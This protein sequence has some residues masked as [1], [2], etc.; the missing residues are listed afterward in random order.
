MKRQNIL[1][2]IIFALL[3]IP[4]LFNIFNSGEEGYF[5]GLWDALTL[6]IVNIGGVLIFLSIFHNT[7][8]CSKDFSVYKLIWLQELFIILGIFG[9]VLGITSLIVNMEIPP[10]PGVDP[11]GSLISSMA[12]CSLALIYGFFGAIVTYMIQKYHEMQP[13]NNDT[14]NIEQPKEGFKLL[15][16][17]YFIIYLILIFLIFLFNNININN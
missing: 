13:I 7:K 17:I 16:F 2:F 8:F 14:A 1:L 9:S 6:F 5:G 10:P 4:F 11:L 15:S 12:V 3:I